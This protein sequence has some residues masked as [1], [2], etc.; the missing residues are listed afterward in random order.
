[1]ARA[2]TALLLCVALLANLSV[3]RTELTGG[4]GLF[5][6][7]DGVLCVLIWL[8]RRDARMIGYEGGVCVA[9]GLGVLQL[10]PSALALL[11]FV[12]TRALVVG[13]LELS[14]A[15]PRRHTA[16][17]PWLALAGGVS[18]LE[19]VGFSGVAA[20]HYDALEL[21][22]CIAG[23]VGIT[24]TLLLILALKLRVQVRTTPDSSRRPLAAW[25]A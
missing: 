10:E 24:G 16:L 18:L 14:F 6:I 21:T 12:A 3:A 13:A 22:P 25:T 1:L 8:S 23:C 15:W 5:A 17:H 20:F 2:L 9:L 19:G 7:T 4:L 11:V